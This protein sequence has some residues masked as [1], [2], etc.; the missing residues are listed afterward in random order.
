MNEILG[1]FTFGHWVLLAGFLSVASSYFAFRSASPVNAIFSR[2]FRWVFFALAFALFAEQAGMNRPVW[3]LTV[4]GFMVWA[5]IETGYNWLKVVAVSRSTVPLFPRFRNNEVGDEWPNQ[6]SFIRLRDKL[7]GNGFT[8]RSS[9]KAEIEEVTVLRA[10]VYESEDKL[11]RLT[12]MF[13]PTG[14]SVST[15]FSLVSETEDGRRLI[16]DNF[17][18]PYGGYYPEN[19]YLERRPLRRS[20]E[21]ILHRHMQRMQTIEG[22]LFVPWDTNPVDDINQQQQQLERL[23]TKIGFLN[24]LEDQE[25]L[26]RISREGQYRVWKELWLLSYFGRS[27]VG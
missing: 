15:T 16:T 21:G 24:S 22:S 26:G 13:V 11:I 14:S 18:L 2:W 6:A 5:L 25:E 10:T 12:V 20:L 19:Q 17:F 8:K 1:T 27:T 3:V 9:L 4:L 7:R 23:N